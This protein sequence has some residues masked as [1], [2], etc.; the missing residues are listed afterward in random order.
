MIR[1]AIALVFLATPAIAAPAAPAHRQP[2]PATVQQ[3]SADP[4]R[5]VDTD[6]KVQAPQTEQ[7][8]IKTQKEL[9]GRQKAMDARMKRTMSGVCRGC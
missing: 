8:R 4:A 2:T 9:D 3:P 5:P 6:A 1:S 7:A